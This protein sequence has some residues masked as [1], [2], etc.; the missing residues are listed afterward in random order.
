[1]KLE[2]EITVLVTSTCQ[3]LDEQLKKKNFIIQ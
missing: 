3:E 1:M 2:Q